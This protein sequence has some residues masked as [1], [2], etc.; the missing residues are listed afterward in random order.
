MPASPPVS[1]FPP[2]SVAR[3]KVRCRVSRVHRHR[4]RGCRR[5]AP[6]RDSRWPTRSAR[7]FQPNRGS[8]SPRWLEA[9]GVPMR[10]HLHNSRNT[11]LANAVGA[12][13]RWRFGPRCQHRRASAAA[14]SPPARPGNI[15]TE[16]L[17]HMLEHMG[18]T[19][20]VDVGVLLDTVRR[21]ADHRPPRHRECSARQACSRALMTRNDI[22]VTSR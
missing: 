11:G 12:T 15:A 10:V 14:R 5:P 3:S 22:A 8:R 2:R 19:T 17:V 7:P 4:Q 1:P 16:D 9:T 21:R 20:G 13:P 6:T 18:V